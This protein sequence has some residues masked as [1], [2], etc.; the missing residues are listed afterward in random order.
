MEELM[1][2]LNIARDFAY[3]W[4]MLGEG[5]PEKDVPNLQPL[6]GNSQ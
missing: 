4:I 1:F 2:C 5:Y 3:L 6:P